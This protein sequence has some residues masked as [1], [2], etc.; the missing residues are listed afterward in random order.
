MAEPPTPMVGSMKLP[1]WIGGQRPSRSRAFLILK[2]MFAVSLVVIIIETLF[3]IPIC[4][5]VI[6]DKVDHPPSA[7]S[8]GKV[9]SASD[10]LLF[11]VI[12][13]SFRILVLT[14]AII[15]L[16][17]EN[18]I[19][20]IIHSCLIPFTV[21]LIFALFNQT[22]KL[23]LSFSS[24]CNLIIFVLSVLFAWLIRRTDSQ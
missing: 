20:L 13:F 19:L 10:V 15:G 2:C 24:V 6:Q 23:L 18:A 11:A 4:I 14:I 22:S 8:E 12:Y 9:A 1:K 17:K 16:L 21:L 3:Y 5:R 7:D